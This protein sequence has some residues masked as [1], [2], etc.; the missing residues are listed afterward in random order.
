MHATLLCLTVLLVVPHA[1]AVPAPDPGRLPKQRL[2]AL[3]KRLPALV[4]DWSKKRENIGWLPNQGAC[5]AELRVM[6]QVGPDRAK[7]VILFEAFDRT[8]ERAVNYDVLLTVF[9]SYHD[10]FWTTERFEALNHVN[11][12]ALRTIFAF[13]MLVI[14][15]AAEKP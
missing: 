14:D 6:R 1:D 13:L 10:G 8:G 2:D 9:L 3:K 12:E 4:D 15:E 7:V 5:K 11:G